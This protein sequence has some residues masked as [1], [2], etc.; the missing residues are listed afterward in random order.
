MPN[1]LTDL[2]EL[3]L[4]KTKPTVFV[5]DDEPAVLTSLQLL[6]KPL[7]WNIKTYSSAQEFLDAYDGSTRACL[8]LDIRMPGVN[9]LELQERLKAS[10]ISIPVIVITGHDDVSAAV[11]VMKAGAADFFEKPFDG[12]ALLRCIHKAIE[13]QEPA[14]LL[15]RVT[16]Q[17]TVEEARELFRVTAPHL[18][19]GIL[20]HLD[21]SANVA[22]VNRIAEHLCR[23][24]VQ[25]RL[26]NGKHVRDK[27]VGELCH[28][29]GDSGIR[30]IL[31]RH[32]L[33]EIIEKSGVMNSLTAMEACCLR[34]EAA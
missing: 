34:I 11:R 17:L 23:A 32:K 6:L 31:D 10:R 2:G 29:L 22:T 27:I 9:G 19:L 8:V 20:E 3:T 30:Q 25:G 18:V 5:V 15:T 21:R 4:M 1:Q 26:R 16:R 33:L 12:E 28:V 13:D 14:G 7:A 24:D